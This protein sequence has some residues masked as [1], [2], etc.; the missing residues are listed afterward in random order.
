M[1]TGSP[2]HES[3]QPAAECSEG[4][5]TQESD[6]TKPLVET[7]VDVSRSEP[8]EPRVTVDDVLRA[9][10]DFGGIPDDLCDEL[11]SGFKPLE[12]LLEHDIQVVRYRQL[13]RVLRVYRT[14][15]QKTGASG[16]K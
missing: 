13:S 15:S 9:I 16:W 7:E 2:A 3:K 14:W 1:D 4:T 10:D 6:S 5:E 11:I 8:V 12:L